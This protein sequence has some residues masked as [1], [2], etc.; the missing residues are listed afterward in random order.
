MKTSM[1][2]ARRLQLTGILLTAALAVPVTA[3]QQVPFQGRIQVRDQVTAV[4]FPTL[5]LDGSGTGNATHLG[6]FTMTFQA[7]VTL[8]SPITGTGSAIFTAAN[9]D[10]LFTEFTAQANPTADPDVS[11]LVE[12]YD[13]TGGTGRF[14]GADGSFTIEIFHSTDGVNGG[15]F[16]TFDGTIELQ[17][18]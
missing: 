13:I 18:N 1:K 4:E 9:G 6:R 10:M 12:T 17:H 3:A 5:S 16:G 8:G 2:S 11:L 15:G 7:E 14:A